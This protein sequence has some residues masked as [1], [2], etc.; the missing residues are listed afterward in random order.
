MSTGGPRRS[1]TQLCVPT[2][3]ACRTPRLDGRGWLPECAPAPSSHPVQNVLPPLYDE[4]VDGAVE[5][6]SP[7]MNRIIG[8]LTA[9]ESRQGIEFQAA[10]REV[11][12]RRHAIPGAI[13]A[14]DREAGI[15]PLQRV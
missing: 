7:A 5:S 1:V 3:P 6:L 12:I 11:E 14:G 15:R 10:D 4:C 8:R 13:G 9:Y 2:V